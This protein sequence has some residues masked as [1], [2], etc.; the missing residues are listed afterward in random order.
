MKVISNLS[1]N[2]G[3]I[4]SSL[5]KESFDEL[6]LVSPFLS[7]DFETLF[8]DDNARGQALHMTFTMPVSI[9]M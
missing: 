2:H 6:F 4:V 9:L 1:S 5:L 8:S 7:S 3:S